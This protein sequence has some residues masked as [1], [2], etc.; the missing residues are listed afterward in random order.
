MSDEHHRVHSSMEGAVAGTQAATPLG[1]HSLKR[2]TEHGVRGGSGA[3]GYNSSDARAERAS[4]HLETTLSILRYL[5]FVL[6]LSGRV[7]WVS[8]PEQREV[9]RPSALNEALVR[10]SSGRAHKFAARAPVDGLPLTVIR[11]SHLTT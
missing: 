1:C 7:T 11:R 4:R 3:A 10:S 2:G 9:F 5:E 6:I 8:D